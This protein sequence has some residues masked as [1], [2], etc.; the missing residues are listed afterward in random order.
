MKPCNIGACIWH[1]H[2]AQ[3]L[4]SIN[5]KKMHFIEI[6]LFYGEFPF[7]IGRKQSIVTQPLLFPVFATWYKVLQKIIIKSAKAKC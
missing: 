3:L 1:I 2:L 4:N 7:D 6:E 5:K